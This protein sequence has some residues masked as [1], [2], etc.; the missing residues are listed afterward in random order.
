MSARLLSISV[1][2]SYTDRAR[3]IIDEHAGERAWR[4]A[5]DDEDSVTLALVRAERVE[6]LT[7][8]LEALAGH[9]ELFSLAV[10]P[11]NATIPSFED[12]KPPETEEPEPEKTTMG[13]VPLRVS[14]AELT[15]AISAGVRVNRA[16]VAS[17]TIASVV[18]AIGL[19]R[20]DVAV[21]VGA[22]VIAPLLG[23]NMAL[24]L[25]ATL[26]DLG[27][28]KRSLRASMVG[29]S[30]TVGA[31][32][33]FALVWQGGTDSAELLSRTEVGISSVGLA[34]ASGVAGAF[35]F[36]SGLSATLVGVMVAVALVPPIVTASIF[37]VHAE[38]SR[39]GGAG[40]LFATNLVCVNLA[41]VLTFSIQGYGPRRWWEKSRAKK[42]VRVSLALW[43]AMLII[44]VALIL[45][46]AS[47]GDQPEDTGEPAAAPAPSVPAG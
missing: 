4:I 37:A 2:S 40:L 14:R 21:L 23:P 7:D 25:A 18:A 39:A 19:V 16:F 42:A 33:A 9:T 22:M 15:E 8:A 1:P 47:R 43:G 12:E 31:A 46:S 6:P 36:T 35:A 20:D 34:V 29:A 30:L 28:A 38:W 26:G 17:A 10:V 11:L 13:K 5:E 3:E 27:M 45:L 32:L 24:A 44:I 41:G